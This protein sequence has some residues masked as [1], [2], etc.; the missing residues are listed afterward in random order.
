M[1]K[2]QYLPSSGMPANDEHVRRTIVAG[3]K[4]M[5]P[6]DKV[7]D[8]DQIDDVIAYLHTL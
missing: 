1:F 5:P 6:F 7:L 8:D 3:R 4:S 2:K